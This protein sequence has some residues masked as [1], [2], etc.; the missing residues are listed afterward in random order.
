MTAMP[1][2]TEAGAADA[3]RP[4]SLRFHPLKIWPDL[5]GKGDSVDQHR[6]T[7]EVGAVTAAPHQGHEGR[8][9]IDVPDAPSAPQQ[10]AMDEEAHE[11]HIE[12]ELGDIGRHWLPVG[13]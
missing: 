9:V 7:V 1:T 10:R 5:Q 13:V 11:D 4:V 8:D 6:E 2:V 3:V 12:L